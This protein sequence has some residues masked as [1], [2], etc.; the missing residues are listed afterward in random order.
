MRGLFR[1]QGC[2]HLPMTLLHQYGWHPHFEQHYISYQAQG[3]EIG[4]VTAIQGFKHTLISLQGPVEAIVSGALLNSREA[5]ELPKAGDWVVFMAYEQQGIILG[6][7]PRL[8]ELSR[9][10]QGKSHENR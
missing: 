3:L 5:W 6:V 2:N 1:T 10:Q 8:N 9:K 4:Q 7:L